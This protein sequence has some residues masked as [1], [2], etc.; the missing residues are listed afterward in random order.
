MNKINRMA[1]K[2]S[3][4]IGDNQ[5]SVVEYIKVTDDNFLE[6]LK[7]LPGYNLPRTDLIDIDRAQ[8]EFEDCRQ[9]QMIDKSRMAK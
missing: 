1:R 7:N 6:Q 3:F 2:E 8:H 4:E 9:S 5:E